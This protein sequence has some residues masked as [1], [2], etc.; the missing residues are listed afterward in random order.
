[1]NGLGRNFC[2]SLESKESEPQEKKLVE[3]EGPKQVIYIIYILQ[4]IKGSVTKPFLLYKYIQYIYFLKYKAAM[5]LKND[6][7]LCFLFTLGVIY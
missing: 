5:Q 3:V 6:I 4:L 2:S 1:M 7:E